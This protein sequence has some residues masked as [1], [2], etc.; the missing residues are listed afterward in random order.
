MKYETQGTGESP[1][2]CREFDHSFHVNYTTRD[3][4]VEG[5]NLTHKRI[6][7]PSEFEERE[8][9]EVGWVAQFD[10]EHPEKAWLL[11]STHEESGWNIDQKLSALTCRQLSDF[12]ARAADQCELQI[13]ARREIKRI[14]IRAMVKRNE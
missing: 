12:F 3:D 14:E 11:V 8:E 2:L 4:G 1:H 7:D 5:E 13:Q 9:S 6:V 10:D